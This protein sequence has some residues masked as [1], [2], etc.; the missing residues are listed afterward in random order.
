MHG[1]S[2]RVFLG[3]IFTCIICYLAERS[4]GVV[5]VLSHYVG[6]G[7]AWLGIGMYLFLP[8][9]WAVTEIGIA[10]RL[11]RDDADKEDLHGR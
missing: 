10:F 6:L 1:I 2:F 8:C 7:Y 5:W 11:L 4:S 9:N 3:F